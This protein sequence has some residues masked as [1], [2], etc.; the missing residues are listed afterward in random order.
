MNRYRSNNI[1]IYRRYNH[2]HRANIILNVSIRAPVDWKEVEE[3]K[4]ISDILNDF[5]N[6]NALIN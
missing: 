6:E 4:L 1:Q 5:L 2:F 3:K